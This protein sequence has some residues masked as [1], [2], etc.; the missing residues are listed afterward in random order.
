VED[1]Q[2]QDRTDPLTSAGDG[3]S[4]IKAAYRVALNYKEVG[5]KLEY[6]WIQPEF[7]DT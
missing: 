2:R 6:I 5:D 7:K 1:R 3:F 4:A